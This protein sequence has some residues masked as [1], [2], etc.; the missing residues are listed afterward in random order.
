M[1]MCIIS[2]RPDLRGMVRIFGLVLI[3]YNW[4]SVSEPHTCDFNVAFSLLLLYVVLSKITINILIFHFGSYIR[5]MRSLGSAPWPANESSTL[6]KC[7]LTTCDRLHPKLRRSGR[8]GYYRA[9]LDTNC[10]KPPQSIWP[11]ARHG[12][13]HQV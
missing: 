13:I 12:G 11:R 5:G 7:A 6:G 1:Q 3:V 8:P 4:A 10:Q 9:P 2:L